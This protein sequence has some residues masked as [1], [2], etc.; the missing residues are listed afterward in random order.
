MKEKEEKVKKA[1]ETC[2][3]GM[4]FIVYL[5]TLILIIIWLFKILINAKS[6]PSNRNRYISRDPSLYYYEGDFCYEYYEKFIKKGAI[7]TFGFPMKKIKKYARALLATIFISIGSLILALIFLCISKCSYGMKDC[8]AGS[9][10]FYIILVLGVILSLV[11]AIILAH[12]YYKGNYSDFEEFSRCSYL[13][14]R[15]RSDY[16]FIFK[17]KEGYNAPF[18]LVLIAE[19]FNFIKLIAEGGN[20]DYDFS[21]SSSSS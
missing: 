6:E 12:Y 21:F 8:I 10:C 16:D 18:F 20:K 11:F 4:L 17:I 9:I 13:T 1:Y 3:N 19:F 14:N 5:I 7:D 2:A 15:F